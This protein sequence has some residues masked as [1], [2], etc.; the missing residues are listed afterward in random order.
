MRAKL[1]DDKR[2]VRLYGTSSVVARLTSDG[3][4]A[5][6]YLLSYAGPTRA[7]GR[8]LQPVRVRLLGR[9]QPRGVAIDSG[10]PHAQLEDIGHPGNATEFS[11]PPFGT[12]AIVD[13][14]G[15]VRR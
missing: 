1:G 9:Y 12:L 5:R 2:L 14:T 11:L 6:L 4:R 8:G 13:L 15:G 7:Q 3:T 10:P